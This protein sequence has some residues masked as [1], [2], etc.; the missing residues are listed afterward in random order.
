MMY[1]ELYSVPLGG[2]T[3]TKLNDPLVPAGMY[4]LFLISPD[5]SRVVYRADQQTDEVYE[6]YSVPLGGG[7]VTKLNDPLVAGGNVWS[8]FLISPDSSRVI[9]RAD[10]QTDEV[11][12]LYSVPLAGGTVTKLNDPLVAGGDV[13]LT[14]SSVLTAAGLYTG[15]IRRRMMFLNSIPYLLAVEL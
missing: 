12:E 11:M 15:L 9:Y 7:T 10:Q 13:R 1:I 2:G 5:S 8:D 3:V 14:F 6:L 4:L